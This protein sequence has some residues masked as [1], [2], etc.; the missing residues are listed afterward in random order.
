MSGPASLKTLVCRGWL[1]PDRVCAHLCE[2]TFLFRSFHQGQEELL[3]QL[4]VHQGPLLSD[5]NSSVE[6]VGMRAVQGDTVM[7]ALCGHGH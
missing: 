3:S 2:G 7:V 4:A 5:Q 1:P 6:E